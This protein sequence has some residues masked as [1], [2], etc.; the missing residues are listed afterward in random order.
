MRWELSR[1]SLTQPAGPLQG[2]LQVCQSKVQAGAHLASRMLSS[3]CVQS[4]PYHV[5]LGRLKL[6]GLQALSILHVWAE[7]CW[8]HPDSECAAQLC[9]QS[10]LQETSLSVSAPHVLLVH[11]PTPSHKAKH[12]CTPI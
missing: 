5:R 3:V 7:W 8:H 10:A 6:D 1:S 2:P 12:S 11:H 4:W 9:A